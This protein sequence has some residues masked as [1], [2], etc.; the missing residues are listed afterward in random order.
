MN[1]VVDTLLE[2]GATPLQII[3]SQPFLL[4]T[5]GR[6]TV[7]LAAQEAR[8]FEGFWR[9]GV[10]FFVYGRRVVLHRRLE[11]IQLLSE[12]LLFDKRF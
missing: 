7:E 5:I 6:V 3:D 8:L 11:L 1:G 10:N 9:G 2:D 12:I 4:T